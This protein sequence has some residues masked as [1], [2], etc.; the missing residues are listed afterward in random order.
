MPT[1]SKGR[2]KPGESG[3]PK[4]KPKG[5]KDRRTAWRTALADELPAIIA[6]LVE[7][8][9]AG[10]VQA[11][12]LILSRVAPPLRPQ[13]EPVELPALAKAGS[14]ADQ[15]RAVLVAVATG[16]LSTDQAGELLAALANAAAAIEVDELQ[17]R[18]AAL[19]AQANGEQ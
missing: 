4:G 5:A 9:R 3:N 2:W 19:E 11:A 18:I 8:A 1:K 6:R 17:A 10:D 13:R 16:A 7:A 14:L 15:A 12:A